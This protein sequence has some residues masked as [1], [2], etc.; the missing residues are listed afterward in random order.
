MSLEFEMLDITIPRQQTI[1]RKRQIPKVPLFMRID[2]QKSDDYD[3]K[4][5]SL[6]PYHHGKLELNFV[7]DFKPKALEMFIHG[8]NKKQDFFLEEILR[9]IDD[10]RSCYLEEFVNKYNDYEF[11][12]M[13]LLDACFILNDIEISTRS[14]PNS[15]SKQSNT[16]KHLG[17][18]VYL[19]TRRDLYLLENQ[20]PFLVL[21]LL[22]KLR[23]DDDQGGGYHSFEEKVKSYCSQMFFDKQEDI[24]MKE[25]TIIETDPPH[26]LEVFR[27]V[28][29]N[30][31]DNEAN[32]TQLRSYD[33]IFDY[34]RN[35]WRKNHLSHKS[36]LLTNVFRSVMDLKS[37]GIHLRPSGIDSLKGVRFTSHYYYGKLK[38][39]CWYVSSYTKVFFMNMIAYELC[40]NGP[41]D[42][43]VSYINFMKSLVISP[44]DVKELREEKIIFNTLGS[45]EEVV[46]VYKGLKTYGADDPLL[47]KNVKRNIQEHYNS[48]GKT[49]IAELIDTYFNSPWP[50]IALIVTV[51]LTFLTIVQTYYGSPFYHS[52]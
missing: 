50:L 11:A 20:V 40:P 27:R 35:C 31:S 14:T 17:I 30:G 8:S 49:W 52:S 45:D 10:F 47:F 33:F 16:I 41:I 4:V 29:V 22:V 12:R 34:F 51:F 21:K 44:N 36:G 37:K 39:P 7:E 6:G 5:V 43:D 2:N 13:M 9:E 28:L 1:S 32:A 25:N 23:Y 19:V 38:L 15:A 26:L 24:K 18:A 42:R 3:P 48:K 46:Q